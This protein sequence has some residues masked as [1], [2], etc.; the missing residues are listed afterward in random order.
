MKRR[1]AEQTAVRKF[2]S[3]GDNLDQQALEYKFMPRRE[4]IMLRKILR[5]SG[6]KVV[7]NKKVG[8]ALQT[9]GQLTYCQMNKIRRM[10]KK[11]GVN[12]QNEGS[13]RKEFKRMISQDIKVIEN[14]FQFTNADGELF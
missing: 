11:H 3:A 9:H 5:T 4:K 2:A 13:V 14:E 6:P 10:L 7:I 1:V 12:F 8:V